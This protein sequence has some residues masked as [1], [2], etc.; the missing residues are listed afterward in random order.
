MVLGAYRR[1]LMMDSVF[2]AK[3]EKRASPEKEEGRES[4]DLLGV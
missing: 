4:V 2:L 1:T 3:Q